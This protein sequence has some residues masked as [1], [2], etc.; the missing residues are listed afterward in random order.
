MDYIVCNPPYI[1][2]NEY[3][4]LSSE[5]KDFEPKLALLAGPTGLEFYIRL[6]DEL[7][8]YLNP[9]GKVWLEIGSTQGN[10]VLARFSNSIWKSA[11]LHK[12]WAGH[13]RFIS[14]EIE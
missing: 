11:S 13:D 3:A 4:L 7:P 12:D 9:H 8:R 10:A 14:L 6:S 1:S 2:G 5:V